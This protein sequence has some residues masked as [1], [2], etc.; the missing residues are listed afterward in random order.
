MPGRGRPWTITAHGFP[1]IGIPGVGP[2]LTSGFEIVGRH[3]LLASALL[4][5]EG[6]SSS[7]H[8]R[9]IATAHGLF[10]KLWKTSRGPD[11]EDVQLVIDAIA[12][13]S[14]EVGPISTWRL[15]GGLRFRFRT[16]RFDRR[17]CRGF[18][19]LWCTGG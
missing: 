10:P 15:C 8:K 12:F 19:R 5:G 1:E 2:Q 16:G 14:P 13:R 11:G 7:S 3:H 9:G 17:S 18:E 6:P 4:D